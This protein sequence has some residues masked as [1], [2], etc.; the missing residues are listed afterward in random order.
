MTVPPDPIPRL[1]LEQ[2]SPGGFE[3]EPAAARPTAWERR[4]LG[5]ETVNLVLP[6]SQQTLQAW[7]HV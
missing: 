3:L 1:R 5:K 2:G 4:W 6:I 7:L